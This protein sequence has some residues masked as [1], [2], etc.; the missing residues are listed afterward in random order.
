VE[1]HKKLREQ[2]GQLR[3]DE[4]PVLSEIPTNDRETSTELSEPGF[5]IVSR[6]G[7][8]VDDLVTL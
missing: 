5:V 6:Q 8:F 1:F 7:T 3:G 2:L 4:S